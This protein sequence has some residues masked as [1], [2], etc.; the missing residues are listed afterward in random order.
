VVNANNNCA[1]VIDAHVEI[2]Q[3]DALGNYSQYGTETAQTYLRGIQPTNGNGEVTFTTV[4]PGWYRGGRRTSTW[5]WCATT[6]R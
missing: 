4:Y 5:K 2:W 6:H 3:C 1:P